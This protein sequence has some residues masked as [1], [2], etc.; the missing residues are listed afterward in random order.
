M[1]VLAADL[2][3]TEGLVGIEQRLAQ[4]DAI[5]LLVNSAGFDIGTPPP[6]P[7]PTGWTRHL[8][9]RG[10]ADPAVPRSSPAFVARGGGTIINIASVAAIAPPGILNGVYSASK[11]FV[12]SFSQAL[13]HELGPKRPA[14]ADGAAGRDPHAFW[15]ACG[16]PVAALPQQI[17]MKAEDTVDAALAGLDLTGNRLPAATR[18]APPACGHQA[19]A[20]PAGRPLA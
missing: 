9:E 14:C 17:V 8:A 16:I 1:E 6:S 11:A 3:A 5:R 7:T 18:R 12:E 13:Q 19:P 15:D 20:A 2:S 10:G 4:D